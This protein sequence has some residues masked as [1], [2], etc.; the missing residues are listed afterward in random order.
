MKKEGKVSLTI[1]G[2]GHRVIDGPADRFVELQVTDESSNR[3]ILT[4][5]LTGAELVSAIAGRHLSHVDCTWG[6]VDRVGWTETNLELSL[7]RRDD[8]GK[9]AAL[10][11]QQQLRE[12]YPGS[13][14]YYRKEDL[15]NPHRWRGD[16]VLVLFWVLSP[17]EE[18]D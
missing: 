2:T 15:T 10:E 5:N 7:S 14:V 12:A 4:I 13:D 6:P 1:N 9:S 8:H 17:P 11:A 3:V 18:K 16:D